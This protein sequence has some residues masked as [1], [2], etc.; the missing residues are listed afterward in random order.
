MHLPWTQPTPL[1]L[2][3]LL[4]MAQASDEWFAANIDALAA[5][6]AARLV[7]AVLSTIR[8]SVARR[9]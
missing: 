3:L 2:A 8:A 6:E 1:L 9:P 4:G 5:D 7:G